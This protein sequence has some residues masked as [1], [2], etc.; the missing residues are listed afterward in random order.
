MNTKKLVLFDIDGTLIYHADSFHFEEQYEHAMEKVYGVKHPFVMHVYNGTVERYIAWDMAR[1]HGITRSEFLKKF[2]QYIE[3]MHDLLE[4]KVGKEKLFVPIG[5]AVSL[6]EKLASHDDW[7]LGIITGNAERI[8]RWKLEHT[9]L[10]SYFHFGLFGDAAD[11]R[12]ELAGMV[13]EKAKKQLGVDLAPQD[14]VVIGD[15]IYD[16]RCGKAIGAKTIAVTTGFH[17][18]RET[19]AAEKPDYLVDSLL[20]PRILSLFSLA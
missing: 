10:S 18:E 14:I 8:A 1:Q 6:V 3:A 16:I 7:I 19:L 9:G 17:I 11:D 12:M 4:S 2:P 5:S 15:T 13:F 20:N